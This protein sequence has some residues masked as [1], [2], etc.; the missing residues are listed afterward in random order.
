MGN[1]PMDKNGCCLAAADG[2]SYI[3][4]GSRQIVIG[5]RNLDVVFEQ[6]RLVSREPELVP[7]NELIDLARKYN[8]IPR[9]DSIERDYGEALRR[10]YRSYYDQ[11][12][13]PK[14]PA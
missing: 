9:N 4:I 1:S 13:T 6:L 12:Q 8:Y 10:A 2:I 5:M 3:R 7:D 11:R 14:K